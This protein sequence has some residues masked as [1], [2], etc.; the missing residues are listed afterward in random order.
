MRD[1]QCRY[2]LLKVSNQYPA[3]LNKCHILLPSFTGTQEVTVLPQGERLF[4]FYI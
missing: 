1:D 4:I 3:S 2:L